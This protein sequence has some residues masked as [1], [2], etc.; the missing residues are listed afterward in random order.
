MEAYEKGAISKADAGL[1]LGWG[2]A[3]A[4]LGLTEAIGQSQGLGKTLG[5]GV[6]KAAKAIGKGSDAYAVAVKGLAVPMHDPRAYFSMAGAYATSPNGADCVHG[7]PLR[8]EQDYNVAEAG[9]AHRLGRTDQKNKALAVKAAQDLMGAINSAAVCANT[10]TGVHPMHIA[11]VLRA[12][13]GFDYSAAEV[14]QVGERFVN[15]VRKY[16]LAAGISGADDA[17]PARL[18]EPRGN[19]AETKKPDLARQLREYYELRGWSA[20]GV[21]SAEKLEELGIA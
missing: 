1:D 9:I 18:L 12:A 5:Q 17:L 2:N 4:I 20:D 21:P 10:W 19:E 7:L 8:F 14:L 13:T 11:E 15:T 16:N 3:E 6:A